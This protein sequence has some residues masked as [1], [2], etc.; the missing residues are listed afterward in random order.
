MINWTSKGKEGDPI[1]WP[2]KPFCS[3]SNCGKN[4]EYVLNPEYGFRRATT[5]CAIHKP[6]FESNEELSTKISN[7]EIANI[8]KVKSGEIKESELLDKSYIN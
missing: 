1:P 3:M 4:T 8:L 7:K 5:Y 6:E 2:Y